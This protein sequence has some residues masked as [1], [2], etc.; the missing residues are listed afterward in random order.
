MEVL[1]ENYKI[2]G[3]DVPRK[4][5]VDKLT[6]S[7]LYCADLYQQ[8]QLYA[9]LCTSPWPYAKIS[10]IDISE[11]LRVE[12]VKVILSGKDNIGSYGAFITDQP[13]FAVDVVRYEG[14]PVA[15][16]AAETLEAA[17]EAV[18]KIH[19]QYEVLKPVMDPEEALAEGAPILHDWSQYEMVGDANPVQ[20]TN[21]ADTFHLER[22]DLEA[23]FAD[24]D[25]I[26]EKK[27]STAGIQH[28][29]IEPHCSI[30]KFDSQGLT[31]WTCAQ[32]PCMLRGQLARLFKLN[33]N[34]VRLIVPPLG[35]AFGSKYE[36]RCEPIVSALAMRTKGR[37]VKLVLSRTEEYLLGGVRGPSYVH[38]K[39]G[40]KKDGT[41]TAY[42]CVVLYDTGAYSTTGPRTSY[43]SG[44]AA[45]GPYRIPNIMVDNYCVVTNKHLAT[46]YRGFGVS[47]ISW[48]YESH[49]DILAKELGMDPMEFRLKNILQDGDKAGTG[50][51]LFSCGVKECVEEVGRLMEWKKG[52]APRLTADGKLRGR[53]IAATAKVTGTPSGS[54]INT[55]FNDDGTV[56][57][58]TSGIDMGQGSNTTL[59]MIVA[60]AMGLPLEN[61]LVAPVIDTLYTPYEKTTTGSRLTFHTGNSCLL[62]C[63]DML[64]QLRTLAS[65]Y[66]KI[67]EDRVSIAEGVISGILENGTTISYPLKVI[68]KTGIMKDAEPVNGNGAYSTLRIFDKPNENHQSDRAVAFWFWSAHGCEVE[69]DPE[70]GKVEIV[71]YVATHDIGKVIN[72]MGA[73]GQVEGSIVMGLGNALLEELIYDDKSLLKNANMVDYKVPTFKDTISNLTISFIEKEHREG[74]YG[75]K[76]IGE[77][78]LTPVAPAIGNA[79]ADAIGRRLYHLPMKA[80]DIFKAVHNKPED[81]ACSEEK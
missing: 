31:I 43:N 51:M 44:L 72:R 29:P 65:R 68:K 36:L 57:I 19:V 8:G 42:K 79:V 70:T 34:Q 22:G 23:G 37:P 32:S 55:K 40:V 60:E 2:V 69:V 45:I 16:V 62:A 78:P 56:T 9:A 81:P 14:E 75:A 47:E 46:A 25:I 61:V 4:D 21:R 50:E 39:T 5:A 15:A 18:K 28:V 63:D 26:I 24:A 17:L 49:M 59:A 1:M 67:T 77:P 38:L 66:W 58:L 54:S 48:A 30:A 53:G 76:G 73:I 74:P 13:V 11:A 10:C 52:I 20:G 3:K 71:K 6:G 7:T 27:Y 64:K 35:G 33:L 41:L 80:D 12:G